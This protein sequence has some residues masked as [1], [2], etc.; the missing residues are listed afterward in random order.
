MMPPMSTGNPYQDKINMENFRRQKKDFD[1]RMNWVDPK[2]D[3]ITI[4]LTQL[5]PSSAY[6]IRRELR[7]LVY[8]SIN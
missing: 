3:L 6:N 2:E 5:V 1:D 4:F 7:T 8:S